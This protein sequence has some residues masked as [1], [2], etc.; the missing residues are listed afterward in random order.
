MADIK[1][2]T[3][4][5]NIKNMFLFMIAGVK[6]LKYLKKIGERLVLSWCILY[7]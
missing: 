7:F 3:T 2:V 1:L 6:K 4:K 5:Y